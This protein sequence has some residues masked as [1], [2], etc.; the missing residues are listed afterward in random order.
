MVSENNH[1]WL[2]LQKCE[3]TTQARDIIQLVL[4]LGMPSHVAHHKTNWAVRYNTIVCEDAFW[5]LTKEYARV[6]S[7]LGRHVNIK[8]TKTISSQY[9]VQPVH[10]R[11]EA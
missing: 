3:A 2:L 6:Q 4:S 5:V 10:G 8:M 1:M 7:R 9:H 11:A